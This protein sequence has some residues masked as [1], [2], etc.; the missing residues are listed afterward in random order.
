MHKIV[1]CP[2][3][4]IFSLLLCQ[5]ATAAPTDGFC[6]L[7]VHVT[8]FDGAPIT[9]TWVELADPSGKVVLREIMHG[10]TLQVCDFGFGSYVLHVGTNECLPVTISNIRLVF[11]SPLSLNVVLNGCGY[12]ETMRKACLLYFRVVGDDG[13]PVPAATFSPRL[14][15][16]APEVDS[17]GR[18]QDLFKDSHDVTFVAPGFESQVAHIQ[19][20]GT[21][22]VDQLITMKRTP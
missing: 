6:A 7:T 12:R 4:L 22:E 10:P 11:G 2:T 19:C 8:G 14:T 15:N 1:I 5:V 9:S 3:I 18:Y 17:Y 13:K 16:Q 20:K 21:E